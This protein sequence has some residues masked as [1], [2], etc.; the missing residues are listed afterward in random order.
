MYRIHASYSLIFVA[1]LRESPNNGLSNYQH[2]KYRNL[3]FPVK[4]YRVGSSLIHKE[5]FD[6]I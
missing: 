4:S 5:K 2:V 1:E 3:D 6:S